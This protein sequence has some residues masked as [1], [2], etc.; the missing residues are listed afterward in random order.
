MRPF[1]V[2]LVSLAL[3]LAASGC[4]RSKFDLCNADPP[5]PECQALDAGR[6][7]GVDAATD[8]A[9]ADDAGVDAGID[10]ASTD[11]ASSGG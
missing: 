11:A 9:G 6:D 10:A 3:A 2:A 5:D 4:L 1:V 7:V 8:D